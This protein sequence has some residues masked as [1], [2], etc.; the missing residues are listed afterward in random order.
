MQAQAVGV[1]VA[2]ATAS[3]SGTVLGG[4]ACMLSTNGDVKVLVLALE[5]WLVVAP[6]DN[7][8]TSRIR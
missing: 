6:F 4:W 2:L 3:E 5:K 7:F 1:H 8:A